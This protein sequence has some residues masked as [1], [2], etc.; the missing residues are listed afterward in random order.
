MFRKER[1]FFLVLFNAFLVA[2]FSIFVFSL[3][4]NWHESNEEARLKQQKHLAF[5]KAESYFSGITEMMSKLSVNY[6]ETCPQSFVYAMR[7]ELF[8]IQGGIEFGVIDKKGDHAIIT[9]DS[10]GNKVVQKVDM[11]LPFDGFVIIGPFDIKSLSEPVFIIKKSYR[12]QE[13]NI[14]VK[15]STIEN[16]LPKSSFLTFSILDN[17]SLASTFYKQSAHIKNLSYLAIP[18]TNANKINYYIIPT[19]ILF[20]IIC[21]FLLTPRMLR[22]FELNDLKRKINRN[23]FYNVYQPIVNVESKKLFSIEVFLR[24]KSDQGAGEIAKII[25]DFDLY[26]EHTLFQIA[27][28]EKSFTEQFIRDNNFQINVSSKH[29]ESDVFVARIK[30]LNELI[31]LSLILEITEDENL[32]KHREKIKEN[33]SALRKA[34]CRFAIDDF[35]MEYSGLSYVSEFDFEIIKTDKIFMGDSPKNNAIMKAIKTLSKE[36]N[37]ACIAEGVENEENIR[38]LKEMGVV[39]HQ[40]WYH[41]K[42]MSAHEVLKYKL[43][44]ENASQG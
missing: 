5:A 26:I 44:Y 9:C 31:R 18:N 2:V 6:Q 21:L 28:I 10:W 29:I 19:I 17:V 8:K 3:E 43:A 20:F 32:M 13:Y 36:L 39:L 33:M 24:S 12:Q 35:G 34:G 23:Y 22:W 15:Q 41:N 4:K 27:E 16:L 1:L 14:V 42:A 7:Q 25:K 30:E 38:H 40:G 37:I 11:P